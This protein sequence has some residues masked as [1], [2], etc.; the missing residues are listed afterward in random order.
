MNRA[1]AQPE[2]PRSPITRR[3]DRHLSEPTNAL[4]VM[5]S[6]REALGHL[7]TVGVT[8]EFAAEAA[9]AIPL[10][11]LTTYARGS[12]ARAVAPKLGAHEIFDGAIYSAVSQRYEGA[13]LDLRSLSSSL[14]V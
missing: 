9:A 1:P 14:N 11:T 13:W 6:P 10:P 8:P 7:A 12:A 5:T 2:L 3:R 4:R